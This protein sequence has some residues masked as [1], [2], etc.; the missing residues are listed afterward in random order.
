[1]L[2]DCMTVCL[3]LIAGQDFTHSTQ[4]F[5]SGLYRGNPT[6]DWYHYEGWP[7][8][9][10]L[11]IMQGIE[12]AHQQMNSNT[13]VECSFMAPGRVLMVCTMDSAVL[14]LGTSSGAHG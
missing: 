1:M 6:P 2:S 5:S 11:G 7:L 3:Q 12:E 8:R 9:W 13:A 10:G 14:G 4:T